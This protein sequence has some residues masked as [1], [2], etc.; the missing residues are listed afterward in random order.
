MEISPGGIDLLRGSGSNTFI[1]SPST[2]VIDMTLKDWGV[3]NEAAINKYLNVFS[4][5]WEFL[6]VVLN[7]LR[8]GS[9]LCHVAFPSILCFSKYSRMR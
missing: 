1:F 6:E 2:F 9:F 7:D 5:L 4:H 3:F 8:L